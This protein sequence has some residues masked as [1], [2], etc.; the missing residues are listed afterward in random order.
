MDAFEY[1]FEFFL[2]KQS[3]T[4]MFARTSYHLLK[5]ISVFPLDRNFRNPELALE[6]KVWSSQL[7]IGHRGAGAAV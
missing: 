3:H 7:G 6:S 1:T 5:F 4:E 2:R